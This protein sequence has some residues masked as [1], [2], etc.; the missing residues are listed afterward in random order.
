MN[1]PLF[2]CLCMI[3][4]GMSAATQLKAVEGLSPTLPK[5]LPSDGRAVLFKFAVPEFPSAI[6]LG[7]YDARGV[8][9]RKLAE[10]LPEEDFALGLN[11]L[12][13]FWD[14]KDDAG[15]EVPAGNYEIRGY[16]VG[17]SGPEGVAFEGNSWIARHGD[18]LPAREI[19]DFETSPDGGLFLLY[20]QNDG[21][22]ALARLGP[23]GDLVWARPLEDAPSKKNWRLGGA[24]GA[25]ALLLHG[26]EVIL[27]DAGTGDWQAG[28]ILDAK[29]PL[30]SAIEG[31][32]VLIITPDEW[33]RLSAIGLSTVETTP[34]PSPM[35]RASI[36]PGGGI[37]AAES[38]DG[39][40]W[41]RGPEGQWRPL[42][43]P[44]FE[45]LRVCPSGPD[46][47]WAI[48][49]EPADAPPRVGEFSPE[50]DFLREIQPGTF[51]GIPEK[52]RVSAGALEVF[53]MSKAGEATIL[54]GLKRMGTGGGNRWTVAWRETIDPARTLPP[55][56]FSEL[57]CRV[58]L[59]AEDPLSGRR[60]PVILRLAVRRPDQIE[61]QTAEGLVLLRAV[62]ATSFIGAWSRVA[63]G[64]DPR[65]DI[66]IRTRGW[67]EIFALSDLGR[68]AKLDVGTVEWPPAGRHIEPDSGPLEAPGN[69]VQDSAP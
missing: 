26:A 57:P 30:A 63:E 3:A 58:E 4:I 54:T 22:C 7:V 43:A 55:E 12:E 65:I 64:G 9:V 42:A 69:P 59:V 11:G 67:A 66:W 50:G 53:V 28:V 5:G 47:L 32:S 68:I 35:L 62:R 18:Q 21:L 1:R 51:P 10:A 31:E 48:I 23:E 13:D 36:A 45:V 20:L 16:A 37:V 41:L 25:S 27:L 33:L 39:K 24:S 19:I 29:P 6:S 56:G 34:L 52:L 44:P 15:N 61:L 8:L 17:W 14:G 60:E 40:Y 49:R 2:H 38:V 46:S